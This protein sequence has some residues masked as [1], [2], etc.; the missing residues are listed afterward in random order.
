MTDCST[1]TSVC[2]NGAALADGTSCGTDQVC[3]GGACVACTAGL[4]CSGQP[5]PLCHAGVTDCSTGTSVCANGPA[6]ANG[7]G[8]GTGQTCN[9]GTCVASRTVDVIRRV[10]FWLDPPAALQ[11]FPAP[12]AATATVE[13][14]IPDGS[15]GWVHYP[16]SPTAFD[17]SG[18]ASIAG[19]PAGSYL[20]VF[21]DGGAVSHVVETTSSAV[22]LGYDVLGRPDAVPARLPTPVTYALTDLAPAATEVQLTSS[23]ADLWHV[24]A[25]AGED[26][27][28]TGANLLATGDVLYVHD[29]AP[30]VCGAYACQVATDWSSQVAA[31]MTDGVAYVVAATLAPATIFGSIAVD[32]RTSAFELLLADMNPTATTDAAA[33]TLLVGASAFP[34]ANPAPVALGGAPVLFRLQQ[35][36]GSPLGTVDVYAGPVGY[37]QFLDSLWNEW[38]GVDFSARVA[39]TAPTASTPLVETVSVARREPMVPAPLTPVAPTLGPVRVP[40]LNGSGAFS[41]LT[42]VG[43]AP[44]LSWS[45]PTTGVP[46]SYVVQ[47]YWLHASGTASASA[48]V[49]S[50]TVAGTSTQVVVPPGLLTAGNT[51]YARITARFIPTGDAFDSAPFRTSNLWSEAQILTGAFSP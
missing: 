2:A 28:T 22:D 12:D 5:D 15:G 6:L 37:G 41:T 34:L 40:L 51:Y 7:T 43:T 13:A 17:A 20:L 36:A 11:T 21:R 46:T 29:L 9:A 4:P 24:A 16:P 3:S 44:T 38:R 10:T 45:P 47:L 33:H 30:V 27:S 14:L 8:C 23:G 49:A 39:Y 19:V 48:P 42:G 26:W 1:G 25:L 18:A 35:P 50:F 32:W 31:G